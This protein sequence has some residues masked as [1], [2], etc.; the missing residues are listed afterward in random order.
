MAY[1]VPLQKVGSP[2]FRPKEKRVAGGNRRGAP[3]V[4]RGTPHHREGVRL[5]PASDSD[6]LP[7]R[8]TRPLCILRLF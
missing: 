1:L 3:A 7:K 6:Y 4:N 8:H 2:D 5:R